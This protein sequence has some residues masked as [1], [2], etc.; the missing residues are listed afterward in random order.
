M[1]T[2]SIPLLPVL[3]RKPCSATERR[4]SKRQGLAHTFGKHLWQ[5]RLNTTQTTSSALR[6]PQFCNGIWSVRGGK[7]RITDSIEGRTSQ[8][9]L[10]RKRTNSGMVIHDGRS[11]IPSVLA[12]AASHSNAFEL[13]QKKPRKVL[14]DKDRLYRSCGRRYW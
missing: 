2:R 6:F 12:K 10:H 1:K 4:M 3:G 14:D 11:G 8:H 7:F 9:G 5:N 13:A